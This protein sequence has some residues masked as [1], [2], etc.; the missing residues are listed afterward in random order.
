[1]KRACILCSA[2]DWKAAQRQ[3]L[4]IVGSGKIDFTV[5]ICRNCGL[6]AQ[7][8]ALPPQAMAARYQEYSNYTILKV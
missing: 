2:S 1:M 3:T 6:V 7:S 4:D 8:D 5:G